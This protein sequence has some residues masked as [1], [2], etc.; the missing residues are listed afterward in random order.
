MVCVKCT[1]C[2]VGVPTFYNLFLFLYILYVVHWVVLGKSDII[3]PQYLFFII[4]Y[5][6]RF[7]IKHIIILDRYPL[8]TKIFQV[9]IKCIIFNRSRWKTKYFMIQVYEL[10][11]TYYIVLHDVHNLY[12]LYTQYNEHYIG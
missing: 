9:S 10:Y 4:I 3:F 11:H 12:N 8:F 5:Y 2:G 1:T 7:E 6:E